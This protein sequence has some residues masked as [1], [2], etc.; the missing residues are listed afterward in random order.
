MSI[1]EET[2]KFKVLVF[3]NKYQI[4][5]NSRILVAWSGGPDSSALLWL[6][7]DIRN[8][9]GFSLHALYVNHGIRSKSDMAYEISQIESIAKKMKLEINLEHIEYGFIESESGRSGR[10]IEELA[11]EYRYLLLE[12][13][14]KSIIA[15][16]IAMGHTLNDQNETLIMRFFQGSGIHG[17]TGIPEKRDCII[18]PFSNI[19]KNELEAYIKKNGIP[20]VIDKT[21][22]DPVFLRN[23][24]RLNLVPLIS[25]IFPGYKKSLGIFAEKMDLIRSMLSEY[26]KKLDIRLTKEGDVWFDR[27]DFIDMPAYLQL[28]TLY[29]SWDIWKNKPFDRLPY[30]F[31]SSAI[32]YNSSKTSDIL[33]DGYAC[34]LIRHKDRIIW[35]RVVVVSSKKSYLRVVASGT[36]ELFPGLCLTVEEN[37]ELTNNKIW[38]SRDRIKYPL[39]VRSKVSRDRIYLADGMKPLKKLYNEWGVDSEERWKIPVIEDREGIVAVMGQALGYSNRIAAKYKNCTDNSKKLIIS[40]KYMEL[41]K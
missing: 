8:E 33:L 16:H 3:L 31:L 40:T 13:A 23:K 39:I 30:K 22:L 9:I 21:N 12:K 10:S 28:E 2:L 41:H 35:K 7:N 11:R 20:Y 5:K 32:G 4:S 27:R 15:S 19:D 37:G 38:I 1:T 18:R 6:L 14:K 25:D 17:L 29:K 34:R 26:E 24:I 36:S